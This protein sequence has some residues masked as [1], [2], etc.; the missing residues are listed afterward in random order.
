MK[1]NEKVQYKAKSYL[2]EKERTK[3]GK[4]VTSEKS[5]FLS[6]LKETLDEMDTYIEDV[7]NE[8]LPKKNK[9]K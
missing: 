9:N 8:Y 3:S 7:V 6:N 4:E 1:W 5:G 2:Y